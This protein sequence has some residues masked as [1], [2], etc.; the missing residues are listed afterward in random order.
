MKKLIF[1]L[2]LILFCVLLSN[3]QTDKIINELNK[4]FSEVDCKV[5]ARNVRS[6]KIINLNYNIGTNIV[7]LNTTGKNNLYDKGKGS[8]SFDLSKIRKPAFLAYDPDFYLWDE[9]FTIESSHDDWIYEN[10]IAENYTSAKE[11]KS[12]LK[13]FFIT[14]SSKS[15]DKRICELFVLLYESN[16]MVST[17][18]LASLLSIKDVQLID[19]NGNKILEL[20]ETVNLIL[21]IKNEGNYKSEN[22]KVKLLNIN[23]VK[24]L[25]YNKEISIPIIESGSSKKIDISIKTNS[26][27]ESSNAVFKVSLKD[28]HTE[29]KNN[30]KIE[31]PIKIL[32][33]ETISF[34]KLPYTDIDIPRT[35]K[36][37]NN[38]Y[39]LIIG[40]EDYKSK[41]PNLSNES[42]VKFAVNDAKILK[43]YFNKTL[44]IPKVNITLITDATTAQIQQ[45]INKFKLIPQVNPNAEIIFYYAGHGLPDQN[46]KEQYIIP[47][48]VSGSNIKYGLKINDII[49]ELNLNNPKKLIMILDAC[50][51]GAGRN[52]SLLSN[53]GVKIVPKEN[54]VK[55]NTIIFSSSSSSEA[56]KAYEE[57]QHGM[58]TYFLLKKLKETKGDVTLKDLYDYTYF[59]VREKSLLINNQI[60]TPTIVKSPV[61]TKTL[62]EVKF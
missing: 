23:Q 15:L 13:S 6:D 58:F 41:Q 60:Q 49:S 8:I 35:T 3:A 53:R 10:K 32:G 40:N 45:G 22:V 14:S 36:Q 21:T 18:N 28:N 38:T 37:R 48:D 26:L 2:K 12:I 34:G 47:V 24:G 57:K 29:Y 27:I 62:D 33:N 51:S 42:N 1:T 52:E 56:S 61:F 4:I 55:N 31:L 17:Q 11:K 50:F 44:G 9:Y 39:A 19:I 54:I 5:Y 20:N 7:S 30:L 59:Q 46:T 16:N 43:E 25:V